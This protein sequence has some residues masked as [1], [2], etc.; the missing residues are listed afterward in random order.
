MSWKDEL[1][2]VK[3][4][5]LSGREYDKKMGLNEIWDYLRVI[6]YEKTYAEYLKPGLLY[7]TE[8]LNIL[9]RE[10]GVDR[11]VPMG[12]YIMGIYGGEK[13]KGEEEYA[14][15]VLLEHSVEGGTFKFKLSNTKDTLIVPAHY[16]KNYG[17]KVYRVI[18]VGEIN[19]FRINR[20]LGIILSEQGEAK[21]KE[22]LGEALKLNERNISAET[23]SKVR[24]LIEEVRQPPAVK[25]L[26]KD[27]YY[28]VYRCN[29][30]F[31]ASV[32][33]PVE[34]SIVES[35]M[36]YIETRSEDVAYYYAAA[37][38]Y[39][40]YAVVRSGRTFNRNQFARP[41]L[42]I[43]IT[44]LSWDNIDEKSRGKIVELSK[45]LH[46]KVPSKE[47]PNQRVALQEV[48]EF[49]EFRELVETLDAKVDKAKLNDALS[50]ISGIGKEVDE[51]NAE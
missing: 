25:P 7:F 45:R 44:G 17:V 4:E 29:R 35:H 41:L 1:Y 6:R 33:V 49:P 8:D 18:Y 13:K 38:N 12:L 11:I 9:T 32:Y 21:L 50:L 24:K 15:L 51:G 36:S 31:T 37:L 2:V 10:L 23:L 16:L 22:F 34:N 40:A 47:Y 28:V 19:P 30:A 5:T 26:S 14:G 43:Y 46:E 39:L 42:A 20:L 48:A 27:K 3:L